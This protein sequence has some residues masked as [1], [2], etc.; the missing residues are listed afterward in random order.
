MALRSSRTLP[1]QGYR[2]RQS[3]TDDR[4]TRAALGEFGDEQRGQRQNVFAA[5]AQRRDVQLHHVQP[6]KQ[7]LAKSSRLDLLFEVAVRGGE[8]ARVGLDFAIRADALKAS[9]LRHAEQLGLE[10][11]RHLADL[12]EENRAA[13]RHLEP[14]DALGIQRR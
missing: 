4:E 8:D 5:F 9:V 11:R 1:G 7:V 13:V 12:I 2:S 3:A 6:V 10:L 14:A